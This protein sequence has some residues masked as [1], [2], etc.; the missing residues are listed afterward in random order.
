M[1]SHLTSRYSR[2]GLACAQ[3]MIPYRISPYH[4][5]HRN[6]Y[7]AVGFLS[8]LRYT[9]SSTYENPMAAQ[10]K[11]AGIIE[12]Q[13]SQFLINVRPMG[14]LLFK[15]ARP[16][17]KKMIVL[18]YEEGTWDGRVYSSIADASWV[19]S[20]PPPSPHPPHPHPHPPPPPFSSS[21]RE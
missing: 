13:M 17:A 19:L 12:L 11:P 5:G 18:A 14:R 10:Q 2:V 15:G 4:A 20:G 8:S 7:M 16:G 1:R 9:S 21:L 3:G 6:P